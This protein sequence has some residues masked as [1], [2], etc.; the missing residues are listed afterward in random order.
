MEEQLLRTAAERVAQGL[1][2]H[3]RI[4]FITGA[5]LSAESGLPT[6]RGIGGLY[7]NEDTEHGIPIEEAL[8]GPM[9]RKRP[10]LTW[11]HIARLEEAVRGAQPSEAHK[12][13]AR[14]EAQHDVVVLTQ[15]IDGF[16]RAAGSSNV[17]DIHG[18]CHVLFCTRCD[19]RERRQDY[20]GMQVPPLCPRCDGMVRPEVVLFEEALPT[21]QLA[22]LDAEL[23]EGFD[24]VFSIGTTS[25]FPYI[26]GPVVQA[27]RAR[28]LS[29]EINPGPTAVSDVVEVKL[30]CGALRGLRAIFE[31]QG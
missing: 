22:K 15:N 3:R 29:V 16:H 23:R 18:D 7:A 1:V 8:S 14:L 13:I 28:R 6:Y 10:E 19:F 17:I 24:A 4:L 31:P 2:G 27:V 30:A 11:H 9:F 25:L 5:G 21:L 20:A 12:L 26:A